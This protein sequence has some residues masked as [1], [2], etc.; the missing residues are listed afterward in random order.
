MATNAVEMNVVVRLEIVQ[1]PTLYVIGK[2]IRYS[3]EALDNGDNRLPAF[4]DQC[5]KELL[6]A[7]LESQTDNIYLDSYAGVFLDWD[8]GDSDFTYFVG[9]LMKEGAIVP[10]GYSVRELAATE[11]AWLWVKAKA[12][13]E[14]RAVPFESAEKAIKELGRDFAGMKWCIDLYDRARST[15]LDE[16]G[17]VILDCF[18]PLD[19]TRQ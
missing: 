4:W 18:I 19:R 12:L 9:M 5:N 10:F 11:A 13:A 2:S 14:T 7:P 8:L 15:T 6:F 16:N 1:L 3:H 17:R